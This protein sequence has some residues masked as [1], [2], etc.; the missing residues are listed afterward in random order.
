MR[1]ALRLRNKFQHN[2][3]RWLVNTRRVG[4]VS[5]CLL[6]S[7]CSTLGIS[8]RSSQQGDITG[9]SPEEVKWSFADAE[10][11]KAEI[12]QLKSENARLRSNLKSL[13]R[14]KNS[15]E[16][17]AL[18]LAKGQQAEQLSSATSPAGLRGSSA[19]PL[20]PTSTVVASADTEKA[21]SDTQAPIE[22][23]PRLVEQ[24]FSDSN[25]VFENEAPGGIRLS[26]VLYG[27]HLAS[28]KTMDKARAGWRELQRK[29]PDE[30]GLLEP[31][32]EE[33]DIPE[34]GVFLRLIGGGFSSRGKAGTLCMRLKAK[35]RYC[36]I[37]G[38]NGSRL[39]L[40]DAS[41]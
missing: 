24:S 33:I 25:T 40:A 23:S 26:S 30:L 1:L 36:A 34:R 37:A 22:Q 28:Y 7:A 32:V 38:F 27:V 8:D 6:A 35:G 9:D 21:I 16:E 14:A 12:A 11:L 5:A 17:A 4:V 39:S 29:Y 13:E 15:A 3:N 18:A 20:K 2:I 19:K 31:R 10:K 41:G